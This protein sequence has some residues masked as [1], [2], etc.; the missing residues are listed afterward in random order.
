MRLRRSITIILTF[1]GAM[2]LLF[3]AIL[4]PLWASY[5]ARVYAWILIL[6]HAGTLNWMLGKLGI[7]GTNVARTVGA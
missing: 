5:L 6:S 3:V 7:G 4:L 1:T 2:T